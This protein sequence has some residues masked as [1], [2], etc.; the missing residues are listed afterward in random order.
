MRE[1]TEGKNTLSVQLLT[2][3]DS[4]KPGRVREVDRSRGA[5]E[6]SMLTAGSLPLK[7]KKKKKEAAGSSLA[8]RRGRRGTSGDERRS[9]RDGVSDERW[10]VDG[11]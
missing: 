10:V 6:E 11:R 2:T 3:T 4:T 7:K 1:E 8:A 9:V 5:T